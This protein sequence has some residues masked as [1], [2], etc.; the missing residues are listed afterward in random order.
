MIYSTR[1]VKH[2]HAHDTKTG[3]ENKTCW[4][5]RGIS[6]RRSSG[7]SSFVPIH[8]A[9]ENTTCQDTRTHINNDDVATTDVS[10]YITS[11]EYYSRF[12]CTPSLLKTDFQ[13][14]ILSCVTG[15]LK[16]L[17]PIILAKQ[18]LCRKNWAP[19]PLQW[20]ILVSTYTRPK[21]ISVLDVDLEQNKTS[22]VLKLQV[23]SLE[24]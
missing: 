23:M 12:K 6:R 3:P 16:I 4:R 10:V 5:S 15:T 24:K 17:D 8:Q 21:G 18:W 22:P 11:T 14:K 13:Y 2:L 9:T 1:T 20:W 7:L 19:E